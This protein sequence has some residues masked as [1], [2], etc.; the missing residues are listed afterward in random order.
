MLDVNEWFFAQLANFIL[1]LIILNAILYKPFLRLFRER[2]EN[3]RG[4]IE[5]A[6]ALDSEKDGLLAQIDAKLAE[7]RGKA[8]TTFEA[9]SKE[10]ADMQRSALEATQNEAV[11]INR[12]AKAD[13]EAATQKARAALQSDVETFAKQI[14]QKLVGA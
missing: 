12:K 7:A 11:E 6:K 4:A 3:T 5:K 2:D 10:G 8:R 13:L 14:V 1:L 9:L